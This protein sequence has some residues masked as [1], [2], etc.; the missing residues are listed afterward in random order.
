MNMTMS[1][2]N[3]DHDP[4]HGQEGAE[5]STPQHSYRPLDCVEPRPQGIIHYPGMQYQLYMSAIEASTPKP[6]Q[7][8]PRRSWGRRTILPAGL[9]VLVAALAFGFLFSDAE[10]EKGQ[11]NPPRQ[12][13]LAT[14][15][16]D[17]DT[18]LTSAPPHPAESP[19]ASALLADLTE[20]AP[21]A[22]A[23]PADRT[24]KPPAAAAATAPLASP[25]PVES[26]S[27]A[28]NLPA[29]ASAAHPGISVEGQDFADKAVLAK[30]RKRDS[31]AAGAKGSPCTEA[32]R[33]MQLCGGPAAK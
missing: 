21:A 3:A 7:P 29:S 28:L 19:S 25:A 22:A 13:R 33:A 12:S 5:E 14:L 16:D 4:G 18:A 30:D 32:L 23:T 26:V 31:R 9:L 2:S 8:P 1:Y 15:A 17:G 11:W 20:E 27:R 10:E 6:Q 24:E